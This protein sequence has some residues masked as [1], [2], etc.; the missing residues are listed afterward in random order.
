MATVPVPVFESRHGVKY[1][2]TNSAE[3]AALIAD[4]TVTAETAN[5]L[6]F[7]SGGQTFNVARNGYIVYA[8]GTVSDVYANEDDYRDAWSEQSLDDHIH[9][10]VI[11]TG[12]AKMADAE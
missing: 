12:P 6:T 9:D 8:Q 10:V 4:F 7:T 3:L 11:P 1:D 5:Q 2:G